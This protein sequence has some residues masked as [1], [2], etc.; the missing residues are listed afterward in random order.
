MGKKQCQISFSSSEIIVHQNYI[1][2]IHFTPTYRFRHCHCCFLAEVAAQSVLHVGLHVR[3]P[4]Q[5]HTKHKDTAPSLECNRRHSHN[6]R[7]TKP[8]HTHARHRRTLQK[9][10]AKKETQKKKMRRD[11]NSA[12]KS[13]ITFRWNKKRWSCSVKMCQ[14]YLKLNEIQPN[15]RRHRWK[16]TLTRHISEPNRSH[17]NVAVHQKRVCLP[18]SLECRDSENQNGSRKRW[19]CFF[20]FWF[21]VRMMCVQLCAK[22]I[23]SDSAFVRSY[24]CEVKY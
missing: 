18:C 10:E 2:V 14:L 21:E 12:D 17:K 4:E 7:S 23:I 16:A 15:C 6:S 11:K 8:R 20:L 5:H 3:E 24:W 9:N 1:L 19:N 13:I 22:S